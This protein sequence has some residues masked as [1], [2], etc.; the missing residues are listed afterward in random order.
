MALAV[1]D[2]LQPIHEIE[3]KEQRWI[4]RK[5]LHK[6]LPDGLTY[7]Q[8]RALVR[9]WQNSYFQRSKHIYQHIF[10]NSHDR[11][12]DAIFNQI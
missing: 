10:N 11:L 9:A 7:D 4:Y 8:K 12:L 5:E 1:N 2:I 3:L 6:H